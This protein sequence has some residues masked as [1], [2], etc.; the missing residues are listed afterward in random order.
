MQHIALEASQSATEEGLAHRDLRATPTELGRY[1]WVILLRCALTFAAMV[2]YSFQVVPLW[3]LLLVNL[4]LYPEIYLRIHDIGHA[5]S[6]KR[7]GLTARFVPVSNPIWGGARI[8]ATIHREHHQHLGTDRDPWLP[9][10]TGHP[11][12]ALFFNF[13]EPEY[14][15]REFIK[16]H[17]VDRELAANVAFNVVCSV[18]GFATFQWAY[19]VHVLSQRTVHMIGIF[20]FNFYTHREA[21]SAHAAIGTWERAEE[22][23]SWLPLLRLLWG[24]DTIDG[25]VY[26]NRHHCRGQQHLPVRSYKH[27]AD[28]GVYSTT[29]DQWPILEIKKVSEASSS[30]GSLP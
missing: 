24:R 20:F 13:I 12:R 16:R 11:L 23:K 22:L 4:V 17:G 3:G 1:H 7:F 18:A 19:A 25:L 21:L 9:Y 26:H 28:T 5:T 14:S 27:L 29:I 30:A 6:V 2:G 10:Y 15:C 8:F